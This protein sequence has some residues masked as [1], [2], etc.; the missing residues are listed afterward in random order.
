MTIK[1]FVRILVCVFFF[2][3]SLYFYVE[4]NNYLTQLR[5]EIPEVAEEVAIVKEKSVGLRY[6]IERL[7]SPLRLMELQRT[8]EFRHLHYPCISQVW[9][10]PQT[11][12]T[13]EQTP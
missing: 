10:L 6:E 1:L 5:L 8:P 9:I 13:L 11:P 3:L 12:L 2:S 4:K 7:E